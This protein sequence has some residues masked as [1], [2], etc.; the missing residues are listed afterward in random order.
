MTRLLTTLFV[1]MLVAARVVAQD[2]YRDLDLYVKTDERLYKVFLDSQSVHRQG[3]LVKLWFRFD[4]ADERKPPPPDL[5]PSFPGRPVDPEDYA[6]KRRLDNYVINC[7]TRTSAVVR[8]I[9]FRRDGAEND[10]SLPPEK[11]DFEQIAPDTVSE[12]GYKLFCTAAPPQPKKKPKSRPDDG[13]G[14]EWIRS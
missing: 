5:N 11:W 4:L 6:V 2:R 7:R 13:K 3:M 9:E 8:R 14:N 10:I 12:V 1:V